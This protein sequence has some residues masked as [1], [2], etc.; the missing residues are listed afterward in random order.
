M[1]GGADTCSCVWCR[2]F[3]L[4]RSSAY[5]LSFVVFLQSLG[6]DP[7]KEG[8]AWHAETHDDGHHTYGGWFHFIGSL[9]RDEGECQA[10][11]FGSSFRAWLQKANAPTVRGVSRTKLVQV[12]FISEQIPWLLAET[13]PN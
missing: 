10:V 12:E 4:T 7:N 9:N 6:V 13:S 3:T 5:P 2:N 8:E 11:Q 1:H